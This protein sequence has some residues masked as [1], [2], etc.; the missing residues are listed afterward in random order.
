MKHD[1]PSTW[2]MTFGLPTS[3]GRW[4][5]Q[6]QGGC[7]SLSSAR[8]GSKCASQIS[9]IWSKVNP[10]EQDRIIGPCKGKP[11]RKG[12][13]LLREIKHDKYPEWEMPAVVL[14]LCIHIY[15][16]IYIYIYTV[17][18]LYSYPSISLSP[19]P[20]LRR[21]PRVI[22]AGKDIVLALIVIV[23]IMIIIIIITTI[24]III[25]IVVII[26]IIIW[27]C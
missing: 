12:N 21:C 17:V 27:Y 26:V 15:I 25:T 9:R 6:D 24:V 16:Y 23:R 10:L 18:H 14:N 13:T 20:S 22:R 7:M 3:I 11:L 5:F 8:L 4:C 1:I 19:T 2:R